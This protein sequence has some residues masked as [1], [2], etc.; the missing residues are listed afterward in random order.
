MGRNNTT[1]LDLGTK[2][3]IKE[4]HESGLSPH[5]IAKRL[6]VSIGSVYN[7]RNSLGGRASNYKKKR[8][9]KAYY[10]ISPD[11]ITHKTMNVIEFSLGKGLDSSRLHRL[12]RGQAKTHKGWTLSKVEI[13]NHDD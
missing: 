13:V 10:F 6:R 3:K 4:L 5:Q 12:A 8:P 7:Y 2:Q 1:S 11:G 9:L